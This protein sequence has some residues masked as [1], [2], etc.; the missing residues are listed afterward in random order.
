ML[1]EFRPFGASWCE[2]TLLEEFRF[3]RGPLR[4]L[5]GD[6]LWW[7]FWFG[8]VFWAL[9]GVFGL[10]R[11]FLGFGFGFAGAGVSFYWCIGEWI[12]IFNDA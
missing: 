9:A 4:C 3:D 11:G 2:T 6:F 8:V 12:E 1:E 5:Q 10:W 7:V